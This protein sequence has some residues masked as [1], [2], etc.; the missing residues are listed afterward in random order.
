MANSFQAGYTYQ[1]ESRETRGAIFPF[2]DI[3]EGGTSY[4]AF[5]FEPFTLNNELRYKTFQVQDN[6]TKFTTSTR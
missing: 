6:F 3:Y 2:V 5:G 4:T 1:D